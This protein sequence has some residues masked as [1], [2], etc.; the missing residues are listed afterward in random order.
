MKFVP[1][2]GKAD[3][4]VSADKDLLMLKEWKNVPILELPEFWKLLTKIEKK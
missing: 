3:Y 4:C 1:K 2:I